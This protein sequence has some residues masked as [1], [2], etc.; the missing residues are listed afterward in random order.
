MFAGGIVTLQS[1]NIRIPPGQILFCRMIGQ[2]CNP[3]EENTLSRKTSEALSS[4][5][6][7]DTE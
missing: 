3:M 4:I 5:S 6:K 1:Y 2:K 7:D